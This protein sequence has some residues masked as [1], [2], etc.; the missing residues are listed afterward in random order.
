[1]REFKHLKSFE[2][3]SQ[4]DINEEIISFKD[5]KDKLSGPI[6]KAISKFK[7]SNSDLMSELKSAEKKGGQD[8]IDVQK[9]L[10]DKLAEYKKELISNMKKDGAID[11]MNDINVVT[12]NLKDIINNINPKDK[13]SFMQKI[14]AGA[15]AGMP[16][17]EANK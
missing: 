16:G 3:F 11:N 6:S 4:T 13:R 2:S 10:N 5:I 9:K 17:K 8:L 12:K 14:G 15:G 1:M 7:S